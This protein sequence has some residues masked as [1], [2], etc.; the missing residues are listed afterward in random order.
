MCLLNMIENTKTM[1]VC[2]FHYC[3]KFKKLD[4]SQTPPLTPCPAMLHRGPS[5]RLLLQLIS[6]SFH[7]NY[8]SI[9]FILFHFNEINLISIHFI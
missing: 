3:N 4:K 2:G 7:L 9:H 1:A 8:F 5:T 6:N